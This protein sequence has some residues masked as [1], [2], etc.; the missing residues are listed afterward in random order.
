MKKNAKFLFLAVLLAGSAF[1]LR[2]VK[3]SKV[4]DPFPQWFEQGFYVGTN[5]KNPV[6][7]TANKVAK[8]LCATLNYDL[9]SVPATGAGSGCLDTAALTI[10]GCGFGD[11]V[12]LGIDQTLPANLNGQAPSAYLSAADSAK[13]RVCNGSSDGGALDFPDASFTICC[14]G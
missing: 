9:A 10:T 3:F 2:Q 13:V 1:A 5:A 14:D 4:N 6:S 8:H 11:R 7:S 12:S